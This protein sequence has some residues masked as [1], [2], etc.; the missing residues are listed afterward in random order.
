MPDSFV[1]DGAFQDSDAMTASDWRR[2][3]E[4]RTELK[5]N[6]L[7]PC[8]VIRVR[9]TDPTMPL[10]VDV[11]LAFVGV[12]LKP[13]GTEEERPYP[14]IPSCPVVM[15]NTGGFRVGAKP[16]VDD[17]GWLSIPD[18]SLERWFK[19]GGKSVDP[20]WNGRHRL[21]PGMFSPGGGPG[22]SP[23]TWSENLEFVTDNGEGVT[24]T[25]QGDVTVAG[26]NSVD[27]DGA[28]HVTCTATGEIS[29]EA[30]SVAC[31]ATTEVVLDAPTVKVGGDAATMS[32]AIAE[33]LVAAVDAALVAALGA[34][35]PSP[36][37]G[38]VKFTAFQTTWNSLKN[39]IA[40]QRGRVL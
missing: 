7:W 6:G 11:Q 21:G 2:F 5:V 9:D 26:A 34:V 38:T 31:T 14:P 22:P 18:A 17:F 40:A 19:S 28:T 1:Q 12:W 8:K 36:D 24:V 37:G 3:I 27:I 13:D 15:L 30:P 23:T 33:Q 4:R 35:P 29:L 32:I 10:T 20:V 25:P 39:T 16:R